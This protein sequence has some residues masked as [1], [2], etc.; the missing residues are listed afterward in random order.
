MNVHITSRKLLL[1][2]SSTTLRFLLAAES[3]TF[4]FFTSVMDL[5]VHILVKATHSHPQQ[6]DLHKEAW[7]S[8]IIIT[9]QNDITQVNTR[10]QYCMA[11]NFEAHTFTVWCFEKFRVT[12]FT[13]QGPVPVATDIK[14]HSWILIL[15]VLGQSVK[16]TNIAGLEIFFC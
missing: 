15:T 11:R 3:S 13:N 9:T 10:E 5:G 16:T 8:I 2:G 12:T 14:K 1:Y 6:P 4:L 7:F